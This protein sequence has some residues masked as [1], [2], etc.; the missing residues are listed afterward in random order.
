MNCL[1]PHQRRN[2]SRRLF[3]Y[4][5]LALIAGVAGC[6]SGQATSVTDGADAAAIADFKAEM[7][8]EAERMGPPP[9]PG[10]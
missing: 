4:V 2:P 6:G 3:G 10:N 8:K 9:S 7:K 5:F 1:L